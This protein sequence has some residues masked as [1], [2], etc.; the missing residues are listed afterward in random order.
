M[1]TCALRLFTGNLNLTKT[2][3]AKVQDCPNHRLPLRGLMPPPGLKGPAQ[4]RPGV[5][6]KEG[7]DP[8]PRP[9]PG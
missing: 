2:A 7:T 3:T 8:G 6:Q 9:H 5:I 4:E 1:H